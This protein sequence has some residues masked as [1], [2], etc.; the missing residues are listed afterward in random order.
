MLFYIWGLCNQFNHTLRVNFKLDFDL[1]LQRFLV[2]FFLNQFVSKVSCGSVLAFLFQGLSGFS[3]PIGICGLQNLVDE[4]RLLLLNVQVNLILGQLLL[5]CVIFIS[6]VILVKVCKII[7]IFHLLLLLDKR[8]D[9][10]PNM[11]H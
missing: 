9:G 1:F 2:H 6:R 4:S 10:F 8:V 11:L 5:K 3:L 7:F